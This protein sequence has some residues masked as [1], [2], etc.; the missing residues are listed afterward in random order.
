MSRLHISTEA[1]T[2]TVTGFAFTRRQRE[3]AAR[4]ALLLFVAVAP[5][6][7]QD[8][9]PPR[10]AFGFAPPESS[11]TSDHEIAMQPCDHGECL[12]TMPDARTRTTSPRSTSDER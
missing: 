8:A 7:P 1:R 3:A 12:G 10:P 2:V 4:T 9:P 11:T 6:S 5:A